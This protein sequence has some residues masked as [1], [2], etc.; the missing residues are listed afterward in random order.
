MKRTYIYVP[1]A[2]A[3]RRLSASTKTAINLTSQACLAHDH[4]PKNS[5]WRR[6]RQACNVQHKV[7]H[8]A[9]RTTPRQTQDSDRRGIWSR[10]KRHSLSVGPVPSP[11]LPPRGA[12]FRRRFRRDND[13][14]KR[15]TRRADKSETSPRQPAER[16]SAPTHRQRG[17][18]GATRDE[19]RRGA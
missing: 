13:E 9:V 17:T 16:L 11:S 14:R 4:R 19:G 1:D 18:V 8:L 3:T 15:E 5:Q 12:V 7:K 10:R 6:A 2:S